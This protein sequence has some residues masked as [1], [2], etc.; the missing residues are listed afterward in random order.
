MGEEPKVIAEPVSPR[1]VAQELVEPGSQ[2]VGEGSARFDHEGGGVVGEEAGV[3]SLVI[4][5]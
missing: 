2:G 5:S 1:T 3:E 4:V